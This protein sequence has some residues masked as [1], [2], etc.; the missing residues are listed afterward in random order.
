M[1][2]NIEYNTQ[3]LYNNTIFLNNIKQHEEWYE[4]K[5]NEIV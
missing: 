4:L 3:K 1:N 2:K 5:C